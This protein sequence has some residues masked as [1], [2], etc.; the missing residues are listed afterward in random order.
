MNYFARSL[1]TNNYISTDQ[2][3]FEIDHEVVPIRDV[4]AMVFTEIMLDV[5]LFVGVTSIGNDP[6]WM[7][8]GSF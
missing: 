6:G 2:V 7:D 1:Y 8:G 4:P 5:D 3:R